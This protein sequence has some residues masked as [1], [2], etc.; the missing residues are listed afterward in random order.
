MYFLIPIITEKF[1][2]HKRKI[3]KMSDICTALCLTGKVCSNRS[4]LITDEN[5]NVCANHKS[6]TIE[7]NNLIKQQVK[8]N[9]NR[10]KLRLF[11][12]AMR[13]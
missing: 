9:E 4:T 5:L 2:Y 6:Y 12:K 1:E 10:E 13:H 8:Q 11:G 7:K 3:S